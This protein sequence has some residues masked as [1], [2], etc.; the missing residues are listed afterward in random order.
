VGIGVIRIGLVSPTLP[1]SVDTVARWVALP[2]QALLVVAAWELRVL[3]CA[4]GAIRLPP[5]PRDS[6]HTRVVDLEVRPAA[7]DAVAVRVAAVDEATV[8]RCAEGLCRL[9]S[10]DEVIDVLVHCSHL[11]V[12]AIFGV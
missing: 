7:R 8:A 4:V 11:A 12:C 9:E 6:T 1:Y 5:C 2:G 10:S 3:R